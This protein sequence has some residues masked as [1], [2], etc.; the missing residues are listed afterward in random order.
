MMMTVVPYSTALIVDSSDLAYALFRLRD[1]FALPCS[2]A[3][4]RPA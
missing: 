4:I 2:L 1:V 3:D